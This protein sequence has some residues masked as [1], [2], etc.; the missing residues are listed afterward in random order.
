MESP[1]RSLGDQRAW[2]AARVL[3]LTRDLS[4][5]DSEACPP[6]RTPAEILAMI[7]RSSGK[8]RRARGTPSN[9]GG[10]RVL[11]DA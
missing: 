4:L 2:R 11:A 7:S 10:M 1:S 6:Q 3:A 9:S 8:F 5:T